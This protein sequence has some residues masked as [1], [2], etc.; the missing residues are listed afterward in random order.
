ML[1][2]LQ[3]QLLCR[4]KM[5]ATMETVDMLVYSLLIESEGKVAF[6]SKY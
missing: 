3:I 5:I 1:L 4:L 2:F 6:D